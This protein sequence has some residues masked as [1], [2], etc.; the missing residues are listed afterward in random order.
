M[1][2]WSRLLG[3]DE[4]TERGTTIQS[5][6]FDTDGWRSVKVGRDVQEWC[7]ALGNTLQLRLHPGRAEYLDGPRDMRSIIAFCRRK[8]DAIGRAIVSVDSVDI[9]GIQCLKVIDK[10]ERPPGYGYGGAITIPLDDVSVAIAMN[11]TEHGTTGV[12][13]AVV[14]SYLLGAGELALPALKATGSAGTPIPGWFWDPYDPGYDGRV[15]HSLSDDVRLDALF[16]D[17]PLSRIRTSLARIQR[18]VEFDATVHVASGSRFLVD[19]GMGDTPAT[20]PISAQA[21]ASLCLQAGQTPHEAEKAI[22]ES[23]HGIESGSAAD[24]IAVARKNVLL[25]FAYENQRKLEAAEAAFRR[26]SVNL[27]MALGEN[28]PETAQ[29][30]NNLARTLIAQCKHE[31]S[32]PLFRRALLV[33]E[34]AGDSGSNVAVAL[35]GLGLVYNARQLYS[36]AIPCFERALTIFEQVHGPTFPDV[37]TVLRNMAFSWKR[38]GNMER[39]V[40]AWQ[41]AERVDRGHMSS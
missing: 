28:H 17:H 33:F 3:R 40:E 25:G 4:N 36:E 12:R 5:I 9:A 14:T 19:D 8:A 38:L 11:A 1:S 2:W 35:N 31:E 24:P 23:L 15:L 32:E 20:R 18:S 7:D 34:R 13:E 30:I 16:P 10:R 37:A 29:A 39:M 27:E 6:R 41:R 26:A 22:A 21:V